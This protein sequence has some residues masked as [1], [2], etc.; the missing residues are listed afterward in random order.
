MSAERFNHEAP[1]S[2]SSIGSPEA[3]VP[4]RVPL[5]KE[6]NSERKS[7]RKRKR[8]K[9]ATAQAAASQQKT[10]SKD[11]SATSN[12]ENSSLQG[13]GG[14]EFTLWQRPESNPKNQKSA[15]L[16]SRV[17]EAVGK[18][19]GEP[20]TNRPQTSAEHPGVDKPE[21][22]STESSQAKSQT[23]VVEQSKANEEFPKSSQVHEDEKAATAKELKPEQPSVEEKPLEFH[24]Q[25]MIQHQG[26]EVPQE[27]PDKASEH[28][29]VQPEYP[30]PQYEQRPQPETSSVVLP[31]QSREMAQPPLQPPDPMSYRRRFW[32]EQSSAASSAEAGV[33]RETLPPLHD[34]E[35]FAY[36]AHHNEPR[37]PATSHRL[38]APAAVPSAKKYE[39]DTPPGYQR[40]TADVSRAAWT[41]L[42]AGWWLGRRGKRKAVEQARRAGIKE[43][44]AKLKGI[45]PFGRSGRSRGVEQT[46]YPMPRL[47]AEPIHAYQAPEGSRTVVQPVSV[48]ARN[49]LRPPERTPGVVDSVA[50]HTVAPAAVAIFDRA[51]NRP[52]L[53]RAEVPRAAKIAAIK[54]AESVV[55][56]MPEM[57]SVSGARSERQLGKRELMKLSKNIKVDGVPIKEVLKAGKIDEDGLRAVVDV[58]LRGGDIRQQL[59]QEVVNKEQS[60][61]RDPVLRH[62]RLVGEQE[63]QPGARFD[64]GTVG[65]S[66][67]SFG[68]G[69]VVGTVGRTLGG[70]ATSTENTAR[71]AGRALASGAKTAQRDIIDNSNTADWLS[72]TAVVV[73]YSIILILLLS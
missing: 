52:A 15:L 5:P 23:E 18:P 63:R 45:Q 41:G 40:T 51:V 26:R 37:Y 43:G 62:Q 56:Q 32:E 47:E 38:E 54:A 33:N 73:L 57:A 8:K 35:R 71:S 1:E 69:G 24:P 6:N 34:Y 7:R 64:T 17:V 60:Y 3:S 27:Q 11:T 72:I 67:S 14:N 68:G 13:L 39:S 55:L 53:E 2:N 28:S 20:A 19:E 65:G 4:F 25:P 48:E 50:E 42:L 49:P 16:G 21:S 29:S 12:K 10:V 30:D 31:E 58:Y 66:S 46:P 61:E 22:Q 36:E 44:V 59:A 9:N 70:I